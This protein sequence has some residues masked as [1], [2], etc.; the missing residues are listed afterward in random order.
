MRVA[1]SYPPPPLVLSFFRPSSSSTPSLPRSGPV[2]SNSA[3]G[4]LESA[5]VRGLVSQPITAYVG[6]HLAWQLPVA[7]LVAASGDPVS[8]WGRRRGWIRE[9]GRHLAHVMAVSFTFFAKNTLYVC[10]VWLLGK[11]PDFF[12]WLRLRLHENCYT[13]IDEN[14]AQSALGILIIVQKTSTDVH[15]PR[16]QCSYLCSV[17]RRL[18]DKVD[19]FCYNTLPDHTGHWPLC[20]LCRLASTVYS[21]TDSTNKGSVIYWFVCLF[22][23]Y[24]FYVE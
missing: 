16:W 20:T 23:Y 22:V 10:I 1:K 3:R 19:Q 18:K 9:N 15:I 7:T 4:V 17:D 6:H 13:G 24:F 8:S 14:D 21:H 11:Q 12:Y 5:V 2:P